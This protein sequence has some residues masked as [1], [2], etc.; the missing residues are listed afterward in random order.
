MYST[1]KSDVVLIAGKLWYRMVINS[2][3]LAHNYL[4][5]T[6]VKILKNG[7]F[8]CR[9]AISKTGCIDS[10]KRIKSPG[11]VAKPVYSCIFLLQGFERFDSKLVFKKDK[12]D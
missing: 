6:D 5:L 9:N 10:G 7:K 12:E 2:R 1:Y 11:I 3:P 4:F 8:V